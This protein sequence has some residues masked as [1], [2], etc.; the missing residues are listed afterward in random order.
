MRTYHLGLLRFCRDGLA[1]GGVADG[2]DVGQLLAHIVLAGN[3]AFQRGV[4]DGLV[5]AQ[6]LALYDLPV[7]VG[8]RRG[9]DGDAGADAG[10]SVGNQRG[11][12]GYGR[13]AGGCL[14]AGVLGAGGRRVAL[15]GG[16]CGCHHFHRGAVGP[17]FFSGAGVAD[18]FAVNQRLAD[19]GL[20]G[21]V[22]GLAAVGDVHAVTAAEAGNGLAVLVQA[23]HTGDRGAHAHGLAGWPE[24]RRTDDDRCRGGLVLDGLGLDAPGRG[25]VF[26][27][28]GFGEPDVVL[29][30]DGND[31]ARG[32]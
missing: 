19:V 30:H 16:G 7:L 11:T 27:A 15:A 12:A 28:A 17:G 8:A 3:V 24:G 1:A 26:R 18:P 6:P 25:G 29:G 23:H 2:F 22:G 20:G 21:R 5:I 13:L 4:G 14:L 31:L 32:A 9:L 10:V